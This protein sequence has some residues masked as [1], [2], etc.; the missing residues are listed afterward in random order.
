LTGSR[1]SQGKT[2]AII[3]QLSD[4]RAVMRAA[5][6]YVDLHFIATSKKLADLVEKQGRDCALLHDY[7]EES[8]NGELR[9]LAVEWIDSWS[10]GQVRQG[11]SLKEAMRLEGVSLWWFAL[12][13]L[14]PDLLRCI[15]HIEAFRAVVRCEAPARVLLVDLRQRRNHP[16]RLNHD[17]NA[18]GK[19]IASVCLADQLEVEFVADSL[20]GAL[21]WGKK[22]RVAEVKSWI[23]FSF[24]RRLIALARRALVGNKLGRPS[25]AEKPS[26]LLLSSP[27]YWRETMSLTGGRVWDDGV[28]GLCVR[29]LVARG[30]RVVGIDAEINVPNLRQFS[31]LRAKARQRHIEWQCIEHYIARIPDSVQQARTLALDE[32]YGRLVGKGW[33]GPALNYCEVDISSVVEHRFH[34]LFKRYLPQAVDYIG[35]VEA[36]VCIEKIDLVC[37]VYEEG[38]YGR[39]GTIVGQRLGIPTIA[40]QHGM[41]AGPYNAGFYFSKVS[42][43]VSIDGIACPIPTRTAVYGEHAKSLLTKISAYPEDSVRVVGMPSYD[44]IVRNLASI[45]NAAPTDESPVALVVSQ[46]FFNRDNRQFF[47]DTVLDGAVQLPEIQWVVKLHPSDFG[48]G[49]DW[50]EAVEARG[51][52]NVEIVKDNLYDWLVACDFMVAWASTT[53]LEAVIFGKPVLAIR[54]PGCQGADDYFGAKI[55]ISVASSS[56]MARLARH[57]LSKS[58]WRLTA[59]E[60]SRRALEHIVFRPDGNAAAR[61]ADLVD[62]LVEPRVRETAAAEAFVQACNSA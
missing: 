7:I 35:A 5:D 50:A 20:R 59:I 22:R 54:V 14:F 32:I 55:A 53:M 29:E 25:A 12:P 48:K 8:V 62:E 27:L 37:C 47:I 24:A 11:G 45:K 19:L 17:D 15:Q 41:V 40:L 44:P 2:L 42:T 3:T 23:Y 60:E 34:Y 30:Y 13:V 28:A 56:D 16:L 61:C 46:P 58:D 31:V 43:D 36:A 6:K 51:L 57:L 49:I 4:I 18:P 9:K 1:L 38:P 26:V 21:S 10:D 52:K 33:A 39:A